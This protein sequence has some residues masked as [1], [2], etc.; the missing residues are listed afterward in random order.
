TLNVCLIYPTE[1]KVTSAAPL[2]SI[3]YSPFTFERTLFPKA[4]M[5]TFERGLPSVL[6]TFP[7]TVKVCFFNSTIS[8][9]CENEMLNCAAPIVKKAKGQVFFNFFNIDIVYT[10]T[11]VIENIL[12]FVYS[13]WYYLFQIYARIRVVIFPV[14]SIL[15]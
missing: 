15:L 9:A 4:L 12:G 14:F 1:L 10:S 3:E 7:E 8:F 2:R 6:V 11:M 13:I 5:V